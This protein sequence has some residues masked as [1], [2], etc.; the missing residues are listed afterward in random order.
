MST[1]RSEYIPFNEAYIHVSAWGD[2][3]DPA[4]I[5][6]HGL[7]RTGRDFDAAARG[8]SKDY[9]VICPDTLG[10]G[11]SCWAKDPA[12]QYRLGEY[13]KQ[14]LSVIKHYKIESL[15]WFGTSMGALIGIYLAG[16]VL[17]GHISHLVIND[18]GPEAPV[19]ALERIVEYVGSPP[20]FENIPEFESWLRAVY[21]TFGQ[22]DDEFWRTMAETSSRRLPDG[23]I[24]THYDKK[25]VWQFTNDTTAM[26]LWP[27]YDR[28][29][30]KTLLTRGADSDVLP[31]ALAKEMRGRGPKPDYHAFANCGHAPTF[32]TPEAISVLDEFFA[33]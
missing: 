23:R 16:G 4:L 22:N 7:A 28:I 20:A 27:A 17:A 15:R 25:I 30:A 12:S 18:V 6:W 1:R 32:T 8:L 31:L 19:G 33:R 13:G 2:P 24:T 3:A 14:A 29:S 5:M 21:A 10:R 11:L 9:F 26:P